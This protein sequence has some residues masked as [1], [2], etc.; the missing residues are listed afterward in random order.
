MHSEEKRSLLVCVTCWSSH[1][2]GLGR[3]GKEEFGSFPE[4]TM[5]V[6]GVLLGSALALFLSFGSG[7]YLV[8]ATGSCW[9]LGTSV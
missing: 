5:L 6:P 8:G 7:L 3:L 4:F 2:G 9:P 1:H